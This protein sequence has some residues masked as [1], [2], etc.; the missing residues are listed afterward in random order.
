MLTNIIIATFTISILSFLGLTIF[1]NK[2]HADSIMEATISLAAAVLLGNVFFDLLPEIVKATNQA[3]APDFQTISLW[4]LGSIIFFF[5]TEKYINWHNCHHHQ[6]HGQEDCIHPMGYSVLIGDAL[7]NLVDGIAI[8]ASFMLGQKIG[9]ISTLAIALHEIPKEIGDFSLL[10]HAGFSKIKALFWNFISAI[11]AIVG[12]IATY[13][14][15]QASQ[16]EIFISALAT[17]SFLYIALS[18]IIPHLH[19]QDRQKKHLP[20]LAWFIV[21]IIIIFLA[22][23]G[24]NLI[25]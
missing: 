18:D 3:G 15:S 21:G 12:G 16:H 22:N 7:H 11:F 8:A 23:K 13:F 24:L 9:I 19:Q 20:Q 5:F 10:I 25:T 4:I 6:D 14:Y 1:F 2:K 17:G